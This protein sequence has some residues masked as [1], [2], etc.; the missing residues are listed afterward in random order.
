VF[1]GRIIVKAIVFIVAGLAGALVGA[2]LGVIVLGFAGVGIEAIVGFFVVGFIGYLLFFFGVG[3][4]SGYFAYARRDK[5]FL[6]HLCYSCY[7][8]VLLP[9]S[10]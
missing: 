10:L 8:N 3:I 5:I 9:P 4:I 1:T 6:N 2:V 7:I